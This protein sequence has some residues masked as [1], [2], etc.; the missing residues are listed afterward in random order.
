MV[1]LDSMLFEGVKELAESA[2]KRF[3]LGGYIIL[4][5][6]QGITMLS[7]IGLSDIGVR[8]TRLA[9]IAIMSDNPNVQK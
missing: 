6:S 4:E 7:S 3:K 8:F 5:R 2:L 1:D 9:W